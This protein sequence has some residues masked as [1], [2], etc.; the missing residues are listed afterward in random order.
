MISYSVYLTHPV[1][2]RCA[3]IFSEDWLDVSPNVKT[4]CVVPV[5]VFVSIGAGSAFYW[6]VERHFTGS[7]SS[8]IQEHS[9]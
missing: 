4:F 7:I 5:V 8:P 6:A 9:S 3:D 1:I 2:V